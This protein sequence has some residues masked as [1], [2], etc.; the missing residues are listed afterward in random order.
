[1][2]PQYSPSLMCADLSNLAEEVRRLELAGADIFHMDIMDGEFVQNFALSWGDF[3]A[4]RRVT[5]KPMDVHLMVKRPETHLPFAF[6]FGAD[7]IYVHFEAGGAREFLISI[8]EHGRKA[9]LA[10][11]PET[12]LSDIAKVLP[13]VD[14]LLVMRVK[15]GFAGSPN[16]PEVEKK[17]ELIAAM[18]NE[19]EIALDGAV[20][21]PTI[22]KWKKAGVREFVLGTSCGLFRKDLSPTDYDKTFCE[23]RLC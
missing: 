18:D 17:I 16:D 3:A 4:V 15:P 7:I 2:A 13:H 10:I 9:G 23:I 19:F 8:R 22:K 11:N 1:M 6:K 5:K 21:L 20:D 12:Q 14:K